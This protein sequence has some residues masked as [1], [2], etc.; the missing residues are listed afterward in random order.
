MPP[1]LSK[2]MTLLLVFATLP[3]CMDEESAPEAT[4]QEAIVA[5]STAVGP[6]PAGL[7]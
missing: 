7:P 6:I 2:R 4:E 5:G 3:A 1:I